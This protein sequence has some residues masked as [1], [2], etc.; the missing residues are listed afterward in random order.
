MDALDSESIN[1][2]AAA[3]PP[4]ASEVAAISWSSPGEPRPSNASVA[5]TW[6]I[7]VGVAWMPIVPPA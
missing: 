2:A 7:N 4:A 6:S 3:S 1:R 5:V